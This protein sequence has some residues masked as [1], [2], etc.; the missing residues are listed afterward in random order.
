MEIE[1]AVLC[2][3]VRWVNGARLRSGKTAA[4]ILLTEL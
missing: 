1:Q 2:S 3:D 4:A